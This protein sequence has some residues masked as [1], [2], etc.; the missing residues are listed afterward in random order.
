M[1][2]TSSRPFV[3]VADALNV[4]A[5]RPILA[6]IPAE[7]GWLG[8]DV[9]LNGGGLD[10]AFAACLEQRAGQRRD[11]A[12]SLLA[13]RFSGALVEVAIRLLLD[14][15]GALEA[16]P[17][18]IAFHRGED[19][20]IDGVAFDDAVVHVGTTPGTAVPA[21]APAAY[22]VTADTLVA[23]LA[24][25]FAAVRAL[26]PFGVRGMW[27]NLADQC[28]LHATRV[29]R[30][31]RVEP[32]V[33]WAVAM[34]LV[35]A[36]GTAGGVLGG[37]PTLIESPTSDGTTWYS[38]KGTCCLIYKLRDEADRSTGEGY[39]STCPLPPGEVRLAR[40]AE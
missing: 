13:M 12:G 23:A 31:G 19:G 28:G 30:A 35:D 37:R 22:A 38:G 2:T 29:V 15:G 34:H 32:S 17:A 20:D 6:A 3:A 8:I 7:P 33:G 26:A 10:G 11:L 24:P 40:L 36:I 21:L 9:L 27:G 14:H 25:I 18:Q 4:G 16:N 5:S 39:C 1:H